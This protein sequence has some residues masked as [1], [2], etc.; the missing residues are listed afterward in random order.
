MSTTPVWIDC[1]PGV[2]DAVAL[3]V[4]NYL[5]ELQIVGI[6]T[7]AGNVGV[8]KTC[9][10]AIGLCG[11]MGVRYP[12]Y[13]GASKPLQRDQVTAEH[14]H[15]PSGMGEAKLPDP[16]FA[17]EETSVWDGLFEAAKKFAGELTLIATA[18]LTNVA[19]AFSK[20][21]E[22]AGLLSKIVIMGGA[23]V[24]GNTTPEA[25]FNIFADPEA[26]DAVFQSGVP[27]VMF[28]LDVTT[29]T[30]ISFER[31]DELAET[32]NRG[33]ALY[34]DATMSYRSFAR[35]H[36]VNGCCQHDACPVIYVAHPEIFSGELADVRV[37]IQCGPTYGK[38]VCD[39]GSDT[40]PKSRCAKVILDLDR[41]TFMEYIEGAILSY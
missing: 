31:I 9:P 17:P 18:P 27:V 5:P 33:A 26:A 20:H 22:L 25:E 3:L 19:L 12:V 40:K 37:D 13:R 38:T 39:F 32:G 24:G 16:G 21:P 30:S 34:R 41:K 7:V 2:D 29:K 23:V 28:G 6:S 8:E 11:F 36:G 14:V 1:D 4:A 35:S 15:G 10:N